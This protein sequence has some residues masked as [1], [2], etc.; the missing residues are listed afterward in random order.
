MTYFRRTLG[1]L[2]L[3]PLAKYT[4]LNYMSYEL[5]YS[6]EVFILNKTTKDS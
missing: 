2:I 4:L 1:N 6:I 5:T 3:L